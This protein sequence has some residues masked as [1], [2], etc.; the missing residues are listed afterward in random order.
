MGSPL[1]ALTADLD[2]WD[3]AAAFDAAS[4]SAAGAQAEGVVVGAA[5]FLLQGGD[6]AREDGVRVGA[7][8]AGDGAAGFGVELVGALAEADR[9]GRPWLARGWW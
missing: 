2:A 7:S 4:Q 1:G 9:Q 6:L 8:A 5:A 3:R